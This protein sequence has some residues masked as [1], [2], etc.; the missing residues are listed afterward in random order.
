MQETETASMDDAMLAIHGDSSTASTKEDSV[1]ASQPNPSELDF[2]SF[3]IEGKGCWP[4]LWLLGAAKSGTTSVAHLLEACGSVAT[5]FPTDGDIADGIAPSFC[6]TPGGCK[7]THAFY[8]PHDEVFVTKFTRMYSRCSMRT[9]TLVALPG[10]DAG[11]PHYVEMDRQQV[12]C[13]ASRF[14]ESTPVTA[15]LD[16]ARNLADRMP[17]R[18]LEKVRA[19][20]AWRKV[21][22]LCYLALVV[23][24]RPLAFAYAAGEVRNHLSRAGR[25]LA[26][27]VQPQPLR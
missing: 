7:E 13:N 23:L 27:L 15:S 12:A 5:A 3:C 21:C 2:E 1:C 9:K 22:V 10:Q 26:L 24:N 14:L 20:P 4:A 6:Q 19:G 11:G 16:F 17:K 25:A 18:L 8:A